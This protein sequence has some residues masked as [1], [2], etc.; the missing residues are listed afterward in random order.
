MMNLEVAL[1][2]EILKSVFGV[3]YLK[4]NKDNLL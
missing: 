1:S 4:R 2:F 3:R